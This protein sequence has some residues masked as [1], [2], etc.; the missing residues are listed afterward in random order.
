M[1]SSGPTTRSR[2]PGEVARQQNPVRL[3]PRV[4]ARETAEDL[5]RARPGAHRHK[6]A[7]HGTP[8]RRQQSGLSF[9]LIHCRTG[10]FADVRPDGVYAVRGRWR[11]PVNAGQHCWKACW[12]QPLAG[13]NPASSATLTCGNAGHDDRQAGATERR[14]S[15]FWLSL[16]SISSF[17]RWRAGTSGRCCAWSQA[18]PVG[19]NRKAHAAEACAP[20]FRAGQDRPDLDAGCCCMGQMP[21]LADRITLCDRKV[22]GERAPTRRYARIRL[23]VREER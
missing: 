23:G 4:L 8:S 10:P 2:P 13:S 6:P 9:G 14:L 15:H 22:R 12:G 16:G 11:T 20:P 7:S 18:F 3:S 17:R 5:V 19:V 1:T 21:P